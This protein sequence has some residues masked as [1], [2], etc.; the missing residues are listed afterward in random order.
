MSNQGPEFPTNGGDIDRWR[1]RE[2]VRSVTGRRSGRGFGSSIGQ[3]PSLLATF[4]F[5]SA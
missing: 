5:L 4:F 2:K 3:E 1:R